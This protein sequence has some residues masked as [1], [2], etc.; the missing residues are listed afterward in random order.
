[1]KS[2]LQRL[3]LK[4]ADFAF[5]KAMVRGELPPPEP[6]VFAS[7]HPTTLDPLLLQSV[8]GRRLSLLILGAVFRVPILGRILAAV[9]HIPVLP[10]GGQT[11]VSA[12]AA[13]L[14]SGVSVGIFPEGCISPDEG[15]SPLRTG[16]L[17]IAA[18]AGVPI[19]P[20]GIW[21]DPDTTLTVNTK[22]GGDQERGRFNLWGGCVIELGRPLRFD[23][24]PEDREGIR[25]ATAILESEI[26]R[27][28]ARCKAV[29]TRAKNARFPW[30]RGL[31]QRMLWQRGLW[32][33]G[34]RLAAARSY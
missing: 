4:T 1:V 31:W 6:L 16:A 3:V 7:N 24:R 15:L 21:Q 12:A 26:K 13:A 22:V 23:V 2:L 29:G 8:V 17:R 33:L 10:G 9:G 18:L 11:A 30:Q 32:P 28:A 19:V 14:A 25:K 5:R 20:V 27:L 34:G